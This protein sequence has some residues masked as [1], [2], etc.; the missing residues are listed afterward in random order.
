MNSDDKNRKSVN[1]SIYNNNS[2]NIEKKIFL[3]SWF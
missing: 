3:V 1:N 2:G